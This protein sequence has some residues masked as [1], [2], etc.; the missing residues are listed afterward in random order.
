MVF[1]SLIE[2]YDIIKRIGRGSSGTVELIENRT[3]KERFA[4]KTIQIINS[5]EI[6]DIINEIKIME[7]F[8]SKYITKIIGWEHT[9]DNIYIIMEYA[10][11]GDLYMLFKKQKE[12]KQK[13]DDKIIN[14]IIYQTTCGLRDLHDN[15]ILHRDIK[16]SNILIFDDYNIKLADFGISKILSIGTNAY[17]QIGT[18]LYMSPEMVNGYSYSYSNDFWGLGCVYYE[19]LTMERPFVGTNM[20]VLFQ[21]IS[22]CK[23]DFKKVPYKYRQLVVNLLNIDK[24]KRYN[25]KQIFTY[26]VKHFY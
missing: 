10:P 7:K 15:K 5:N 22:Q 21:N 8:N 23:I 2:N 11:N 24:T 17:T 4:L 20:L 1:I 13:L 16:P 9:N 19:L 3:S 26:Y 14:K 6:T 25:C 18:P 12:I